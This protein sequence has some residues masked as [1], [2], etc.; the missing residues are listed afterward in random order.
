MAFKPATKMTI[1]KPRS[2]HTLTAT[3]DGNAC[4]VLC[5][6][7]WAGMPISPSSSLMLPRWHA[8]RHVLERI[9]QRCP[10]HGVARQPLKIIEPDERPLVREHVPLI[11]RHL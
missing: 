3:I 7:G 2:C 8:Q 9:A 6:N 1:W 5:R 10:K 11:K 4:D